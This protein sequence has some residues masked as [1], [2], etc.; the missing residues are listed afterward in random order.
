[1]AVS[2]VDVRKARAFLVGKGARNISPRK[3]ATAAKDLGKTFAE[4]LRMIGRL[5]MGGQGLGPAP[6]AEEIAREK[7]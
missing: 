2:N 1:M 5:S 4:L 7:S 3:F 6:I